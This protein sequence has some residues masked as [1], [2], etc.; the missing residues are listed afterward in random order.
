MEVIR[1]ITPSGHGGY[2][3][4]VPYDLLQEIKQKMGAVPDTVIWDIN[5]DITLKF[6]VD[7]KV[8]EGGKGK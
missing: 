3:L 5:G 4:S 8:Y 1:K 2:L 7:G 6:M